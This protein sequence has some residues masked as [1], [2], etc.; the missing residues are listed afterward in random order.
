MYVFGRFVDEPLQVDQIPALL[1]EGR[2]R[3]RAL[4]SVPVER[5]LA[6]LDT[7][8]RHWA[9][10]RDW[11]PGLPDELA[12]ELRFSREMIANTLDV[13]P[14]I[15]SRRSLTA[16]LRGEFPN[17]RV[18]DDFTRI[19]GYEGEVRAF[20]RGLLLHVSA[21]NVFVGCIDSLLMGFLT[22]NISLLKLSQRNQLF[23]ERF[24]RSLRELDSAGTLADHFAVLHWSR[25]DKATET[26]VKNGVDTIIAWGG[27]EMLASYANQLN[28]ATRLVDFGPRISF[29][30]VTRAGWESIAP[31]DFAARV[32]RDVCL[33][34]QSACASPQNLFLE[35]GIDDKAVLDALAAGFQTFGL[36]RGSLDD[37]EYVELHKERQRAQ[38]SQILGTGAIRLGD[39]FLLHRDPRP[40]IRP[41]PLARTLII[42]RFS[43]LEDLT[44]QIEPWRSYLQTCSYLA[45]SDERERL[46]DLLGAAGVSRFV[47]L[48]HVADGLNGSPHDNRYALREL[49]RFVS[50][51]G[52]PGVL[53]FVNQA[54][55]NVPHYR[56]LRAGRRVS[57]LNDLPTLNASAVANL[58]PTLLS[59]KRGAGRFFSSGGTTGK[60]KYSFYSHEN[61]TRIAHFHGQAFLG[62]GLCPGDMVA[63]LFVAG[64]L[65]S[66]FLAVEKALEAAGITSLP[67]GG[68]TEGGVIL[69]I[70]LHFQP[71]AV[72]G[73]PSLLVELAEKSRSLARPPIVP[74]VFYAGEPLAEG[75]R[76]LLRTVWKTEAVRSAG[77]ASVDAGFIGYPCVHCTGTEHHLA[78]EYVHLEI[79]DEEA[80]VTSMFRPDHPLIR[81]ATGDRVLLLEGTC[82]CGSPD[83]R[84]MLQGRVDGVMNLWGC[85]VALQDFDNALA[86]CGLMPTARQLVIDDS[87]A[88]PLVTLRLEGCT[89]KADPAT[90]AAALIKLNPDLRATRDQSFLCALIGCELVPEGGIARLPRTGKIRPI[91]RTAEHSQ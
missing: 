61:F 66:S 29:Q 19:A 77:Y 69:E 49:V 48:G 45:G 62:A 73:I 86:A 51:E 20:P 47:T 65:W 43:S 91:V 59:T 89:Q 9:K 27:E 12:H 35:Q 68:Q 60:P 26:A 84:F 7:L 13:M 38:L 30:A 83:P 14:H 82:P 70:L 46:T 90:L 44:R 34:D 88:Q 31:E 80:V 67:V 72:L 39:D 64:G 41:S 18:L 57:S 53:G 25:A 36:P 4:R 33:W 55:A 74:L 78:A 28:P 76:A 32:A 79:I 3:A 11:T 8:G 24:V 16:R 37:D 63:N 50:D 2:E 15:L 81:Y 5:I 58:G 40:G 23:P 1:A 85:R 17:L 54:I 6:L 75:A 21:G 71:R 10:W 87:G 56:V 42:K 52:E 22:K